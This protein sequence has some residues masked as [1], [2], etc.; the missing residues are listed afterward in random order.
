MF[1]ITKTNH[2]ALFS[3]KVIVM[4]LSDESFSYIIM[5]FDCRLLHVK[6]AE[7]KLC[8]LKPKQAFNKKLNKTHEF[9]KLALLKLN[10]TF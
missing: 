1:A 7:N 6:V 4:T 5:L 2:T 10:V 3:M 8:P 9:N